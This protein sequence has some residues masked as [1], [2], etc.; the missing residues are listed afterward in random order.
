MAY[1]TTWVNLF[2]NQTLSKQPILLAN[3]VLLAKKLVWQN[4]K[5]YTRAWET[6]RAGDYCED[7][8]LFQEF[9]FKGSNIFLTTLNGVPFQEWLYYSS[10][11]DSSKNW[12]QREPQKTLKL[13]FSSIQ[14]HF[15]AQD[16]KNLEKSHFQHFI[17]CA[18]LHSAIIS[19]IAP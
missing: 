14:Y 13:F 15:F 6:L 10:H 5:S 4:N 2:F 8:I 16:S 12:T 17:A 18:S 3:D 19:K 9:F 7:S 11:I 1:T